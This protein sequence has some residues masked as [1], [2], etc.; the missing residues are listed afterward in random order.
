MN[1]IKGVDILGIDISKKSFNVALLRDDKYKHKKFSNDS[2]GFKQMSTWLDRHGVED[3]HG[4]M[5]S[6]SVYWE[7][8]AEYL[9]DKGYKVSV[10]NPAR[11]K[12]YAQGE[13]IRTKTDKVD[14]SVIARFCRAMDP[15]IWIPEPKEIR[16]LRSLVRRLE[17]LDKMRQ[18]EVNRLDVSEE[19]VKKQ[20]RDHIKYL[21]EQIETVKKK[22][23]GYINKN[24]QLR[25]KQELLDSIPGVG[26]ETI[27]RVLSHFG[28]VEKFPSAKRLSSYLGISPR[29]HQ[30]GSSVRGR[31]KMSKIGRSSLRKAFFMPALASLRFNPII[32]EMKERME[33]A[34]KPKMV[35]VGAAMRKLVHLIYGVLKNKKP[36]DPNYCTKY[37]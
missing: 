1:E 26:E 29:E 25:D 22:I 3:L 28:Y 12:G 17:A 2:E 4:C 18:Q 33:K 7:A 8:L 14:A 15:G 16:E 19:V 36:F 32:R 9:Y 21:S 5:E 20:I 30:S 31:S 24:P 23:K 27:S 6:T 34:G 35:I 37:T 11:I 10:V 13:L